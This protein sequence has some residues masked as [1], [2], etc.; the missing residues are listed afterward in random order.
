MTITEK[1]LAHHS[2]LARVSP[3]DLIEV[4]VD[5]ALANDITAPLA[6]KVFNE[7]GNPAVFDREKSRSFPII[8]YPTKT[9]NLQSKPKLCGNSPSTTTSST[10]MKWGRQA[11][12][13]SSFLKKDWL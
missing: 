9:S 1:I 12:S 13:I 6:I 8:L 7:V 10:T 5:M 2:N 4:H 3:G 11:L